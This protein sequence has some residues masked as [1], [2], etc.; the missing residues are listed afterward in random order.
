MKVA[1]IL[2]VLLLLA[3][4]AY[5]RLAPSDPAMW[6]V[7]PENADP[8]SPDYTSPN[9]FLAHRNLEKAPQDVLSDLDQVILA[10]PR[11]HVL[12]GDAE[13]GMI[14]YVTRSALW[15]FP[16]YTT[17]IVEAGDTGR[18]TLIVHGRARFGYSDLGVNKA[19][20]LGWLSAL[21]GAAPA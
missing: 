4:A 9:G 13:S 14:T 18:T 11:T 1:V 12:S 3:A 2:V 8:R 19:R 7:Y 21:G 5:V 15:G 6:H 16:D 17:V 10:T 20:I